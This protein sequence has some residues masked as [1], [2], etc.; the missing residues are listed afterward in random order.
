MLKNTRKQKIIK[1]YSSP[2]PV[3]RVSHIHISDVL[4]NMIL[5]RDWK[6]PNSKHFMQYV[7]HQK[8]ERNDVVK[9]K[10]SLDQ[11]LEHRQARTE[12]ICPIKEELF[13]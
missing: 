10:D 8:S 11:A 2:T 12:G 6:S 4:N 5:P 3:L 9:L 7:S 13:S 1:K